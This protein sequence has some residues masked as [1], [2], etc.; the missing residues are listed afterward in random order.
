MPDYDWISKFKGFNSSSI[1]HN[2]SEPNTQQRKY[3][4]ANNPHGDE[5]HKVR[6]KLIAVKC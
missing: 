2:H 4:S 6:C 3:Q 1:T 5:T